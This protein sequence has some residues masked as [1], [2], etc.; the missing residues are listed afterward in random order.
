MKKELL[1]YA[2]MHALVPEHSAAF[3]EAMSGGSAFGVGR[4]LFFHGKGWLI[5]IGYPLAGDFDPEEFRECMDEATGTTGA[6]DC[7]AVAPQLPES[8]RARCYEEDW[9]YGLDAEAAVPG[10]LKRHV[11]VARGRLRLEAG[12]EFTPEHRRLWAEFMGRK[13]LR[14]QIRE[15]FARTNLVLGAPGTDIRLLNAWDE[16]GKLAASLLVDAAPELFLSYLLGA[17]SRANYTPHAADLLFAF[18]LEEARR[19][20]KKYI[21]LGLGVNDGIRR[22]KEKWGGNP[23]LPYF[24]A[25]WEAKTARA[26]AGKRP[27]ESRDAPVPALS[28][29]SSGTTADAL[30]DYLFRGGSKRDVIP[31][32]KPFAMLWE[33]EKDGKRSWLAGTAHTFCCSFAWSFRKLF[34]KTRTAIFEG[35]LTPDDL[36]YVARAGRNPAPGTPVVGELLEEADILRLERVIH[37]PRGFFPRLLNTEWKR[38]ADVRGILFRTTPWFAFFAL[39]H[40]F[41]ERHGWTA[42][43][44]LEAWEMAADMK[45]ARVTMETMQDQ[46]ES[47]ESIPMERI[48]R[49]LRDCEEWPDRMKRNRSAYLAGSLDDMM[50]TSTEFPTRTERVIGFRDGNFFEQMLPSMEAGGAAVFVGTAHLIGLRPM[51]EAQGFTLRHA[52]FGWLS[53]LRASGCRG[54]KGNF[55]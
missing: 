55:L 22:F 17:H 40:S 44:D 16:R 47:L 30:L 32:Q 4:Y 6:R 42:S 53:R 37:G 20:G 36:A 50:G 31:E 34:A 43:V 26:A 29:A 35:P 15:L 24:A 39:W 7:W 54:E 28:A 49:F 27:Q 13:E 25:S 11:R 51:L 48:L 23:M 33:A 9:F 38:P 10:K 41:L 19:E 3:M 1:K 8:M 12:R 21:H 14:P 52:P 2:T 46:V 18:M 45:L 5:G